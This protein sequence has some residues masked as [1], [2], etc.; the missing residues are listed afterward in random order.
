MDAPTMTLTVADGWCLVAVTKATGTVAPPFHKVVL[1]SGTATDEDD[2]PTVANSGTPTTK[3]TMGRTLAN[4]GPLNGDFAVAGVWN[5]VLT[6]TQVESLMTSR[7]AWL[8]LSPAGLWRLNQSAVTET[9]TDLTG[10]G[11][12]ESARG[13][14]GHDGRASVRL[15]DQVLTGD[16]SERL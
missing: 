16:A 6:D 5:T 14:D 9:V 10:N 7:Q 1:S 8:D 15:V 3:A 12:N 11:A 2:N 13:F 4:A